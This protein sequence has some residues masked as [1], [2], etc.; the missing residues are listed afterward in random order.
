MNSF[1]KFLTESVKEL[2][3]I[4]TWVRVFFKSGMDLTPLAVYADQL[5]ETGDENNQAAARV[6]RDLALGGKWRH[7]KKKKGQWQG[8]LIGDFY[9]SFGFNPFYDDHM[10][11]NNS[12]S[13]SWFFVANSRGYRMA[14]HLV[15][16]GQD[17]Y[18]LNINNGQWS[19]YTNS[20]TGAVGVV[21]I[22]HQPTENTERYYP[23]GRITIK[24]FK[25]VPV[26]EVDPKVL[27]FA[28][29]QI[30]EAQIRGRH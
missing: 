6:L 26:E 14:R 4:L 23:P 25:P 10:R 21:S 18:R 2:P 5:D 22:R 20:G 30:L 8:K 15:D 19:K 16:A 29:Y 7:L 13:S 12:S 27:L 9:K 17:S 24:D 28:F 1:E 3:N 11:I